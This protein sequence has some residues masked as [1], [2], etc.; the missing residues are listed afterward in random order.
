MGKRIPCSHTPFHKNVAGAEE[1]GASAVS[2][3]RKFLLQGGHAVQGWELKTPLRVQAQAQAIVQDELIDE[4]AEETNEKN[5]EIMIQAL[6]V[7]FFIS[8]NRKSCILAL[9]IRLPA[10]YDSW[11]VSLLLARM[12]V[13]VC[14]FVRRW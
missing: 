2:F 6:E 5:A 12:C 11:T 1:L 3:R 7:I 8:S 10:C 4:S 13:C 14:V 9:R